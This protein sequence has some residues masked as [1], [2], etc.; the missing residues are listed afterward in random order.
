MLFVQHLA[1]KRPEGHYYAYHLDK[2][3][4]LPLLGCRK[5]MGVCHAQDLVYVFG[6]PQRLHGAVLDDDE[7]NLSVNIVKSWTAFARTGHPGSVGHN[8]HWAPAIDTHGADPSA[9][10][11]NLNPHDY[12]MLPH[13]YSNLCNKFWQP[14]LEQ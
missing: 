12:R 11:M 8:V 14:K 9:S 7:Y 4:I 10:L 13:F 6:I 2:Q 3:S 5:W 1:K